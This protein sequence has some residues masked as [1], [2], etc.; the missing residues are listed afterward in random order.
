MTIK[1]DGEFI[2]YGFTKDKGKADTCSI[3][4]V[5]KK[6]DLDVKESTINTIAV[7]R[8]YPTIGYLKAGTNAFVWAK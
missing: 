1:E 7:N 5:R 8:A 3:K 4:I 6:S 2:I